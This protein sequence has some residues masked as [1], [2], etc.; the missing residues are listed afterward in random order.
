VSGEAAGRLVAAARSHGKRGRAG[1]CLCGLGDQVTSAAAGPLDRVRVGGLKATRRDRVAGG[2]E[3]EHFRPPL[4]H[5]S[6]MT[7][8]CAGLRRMT[9]LQRAARYY[10]VDNRTARQWPH[11]FGFEREDARSY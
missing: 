7:A 3:E 1:V 9:R 2:G 11:W 6:L 8:V 10:R 4:V 5:W